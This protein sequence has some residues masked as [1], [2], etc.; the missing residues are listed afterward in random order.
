MAKTE[1]HFELSIQLP[2]VRYPIFIGERYLKN[3]SLIGSQIS[4]N[5]VLIVTNHTIAPLYLNALQQ[6]LKHFQC[7]TVILED[8]ESFKNQDSLNAIYHTL[9]DKKHHRDTTIIA[10]GGGVIGDVAGFAAATFQRGVRFIQIPT[11]LLAQVDSSVGGKT[12]INHEKGKNMIGSFY[13]PH[14]VFMD[15][16]VLNTLPQREVLSGM[17]EVIKYGLIEG[18]SFY[19][20]L[21]HFIENQVHDGYL[22]ET[23]RLKFAEIIKGCCE[24]KAR[25]V[26][27]DEK[28][29]GIRA[30]LNLGHTFGHAIET[31]THYD[32]FRH[33]EAVAI[34]INCAALMSNQLGFLN[35]EQ[36]ETIQT[37]LSS[38][39]LPYQIPTHLDV[40][41][42]IQLMSNDKKVKDNQLR[43]ILMKEPGNCFMHEGVRDDLL[44]DVLI[45]AKA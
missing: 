38:T 35:I 31:L 36:V 28:E 26:E 44:R 17:A 24:I 27:A 42:L 14:A 30:L 19:N 12:A 2:H 5:Q 21:Q 16:E 25:V 6:S 18:G 34:G 3:G 22:S 20:E 23:R 9:M 32:V 41:Q 37:L 11:T 1:T 45:S 4:S 13:H 43:F 10:L 39:H 15:L 33:G 40:S 7:D 8:G 29:T